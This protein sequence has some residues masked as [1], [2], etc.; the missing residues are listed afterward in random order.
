MQFP[1]FEK[2]SSREFEISSNAEVKREASGLISLFAAG[3]RFLAS[4]AAHAPRVLDLNQVES[5]APS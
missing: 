2:G 5:P 1:N 3:K 4:H